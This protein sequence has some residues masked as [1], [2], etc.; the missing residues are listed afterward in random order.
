MKWYENLY[1]GKT[2]AQKQYK[3]L[4][5]ISK[6]RLNNAYL[7]TLPSND[8]NL[9]DIYAYPELMQKYYRTREIIVVG[10]ACGRD[11]ALEVTQDIIM[12]VYRKSGSFNVSDFIQKRED[13][14]KCWYQF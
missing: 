5:R 6:K 3:L 1:M 14:H 7:I 4:R 9:L 12:D 10:M 11:E 2:A 8:N 13:S